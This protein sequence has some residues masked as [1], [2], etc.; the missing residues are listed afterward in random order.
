MKR[1]INIGLHVGL[2]LVAFGMVRWVSSHSGH[3]SRHASKED[4]A[5][6]CQSEG[7]DGEEVSEL[8][9][10]YQEECIGEGC[11]TEEVVELAGNRDAV[12]A[13]LRDFQ[14]RGK[15]VLGCSFIPPQI[16]PHN[17]ATSGDNAFVAGWCN[18][19]MVD[20]L[21][22]DFDFDKVDWDEGYG[23]DSVCDVNLPLGRTYNALAL[24]RLFGTSKPEGSNNWLPWFYSFAS[25]AIDELDARCGK[26]QNL[27][28]LATT[29]TGAQ[30]NRTELYWGFFYN[31]NVPSRTATIVHEARHAD[32]GPSH[33]GSTCSAGGSCDKNWGLF[34]SRTYEVLY[35]W[36]LRSAGDGS[37][38]AAISNLA[39]A[40]ANA[41]LTS[42]FDNRPTRGEVWGSGV[43]NPSGFLVIP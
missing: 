37:I 12:N 1:S 23:W 22:N 4:Y 31:Q 24:L 2:A 34:G 3:T 28:T 8:Y 32:G 21:W 20:T 5:E 17:N 40:Q 30:D 27:T 13:M 35:V 29:F 6:E 18:Q 11:D 39:Q 36:W 19:P 14:S 41:L 43:S 15:T 38:T 7:C 9:S 25:N 42:A 26:G 16:P 33:N 10:S